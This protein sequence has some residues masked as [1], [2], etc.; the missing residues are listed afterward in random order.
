MDKGFAQHHF[1]NRDV[2][3]CSF[4]T[5]KN[6]AGFTLVEL[7]VVIAIVSIIS[8]LVLPNFTFGQRQFNIKAS[9]YKLAQDLRVTQEKAMSAVE[10]NGQVPSGGYGINFILNSFSY[11]IFADTDGDGEYDGENEKVEE[12]DLNNIKITPQYCYLLEQWDSLLELSIIFL[13][14][15]PSVVIDAANKSYNDEYMVLLTDESGISK[16]IKINR[17]GLVS[18]IE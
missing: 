6:G 11:I 4:D 17:V 14:P 12:I 18:I 9:A 5:K 15:D 10:F 8:A 7:L 13:P 3:K 1:L 16:S 2:E